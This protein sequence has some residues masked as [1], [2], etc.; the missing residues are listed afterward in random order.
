MVWA[1]KGPHFLL[2]WHLPGDK[3][4]LGVDVEGR[5]PL[6]DLKDVHGLR[7]PRIEEAHVSVDTVGKGSLW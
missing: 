3:V 5:E 1:G 7:H 2:A 6:H 4:C